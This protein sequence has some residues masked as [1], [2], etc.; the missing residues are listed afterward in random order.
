LLERLILHFPGQKLQKLKSTPTDFPP[1]LNMRFTSLFL[2]TNLLSVASDARATTP[3]VVFILTDDQ[4]DAFWEDY[5]AEH[6]PKLR[7]HIIE[8]G[9]TI[10]N[11]FSTTP[12]CCPSRSSIY[13]GKYIHNLGV[14]NNSG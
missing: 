3:N 6:Q 8:E 2:V 13:T 7:K 1:S 9:T 4:S 12:V 10:S 5:D 11:S 14:F